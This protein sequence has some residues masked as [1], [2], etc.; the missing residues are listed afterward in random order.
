[1]GIERTQSPE[2]LQAEVDFSKCQMYEIIKA[3][4]EGRTVEFESFSPYLADY[5]TKTGEIWE[6]KLTKTDT[7]G[8]AIAKML[9]NKFPNAQMV[10]LY[11]EYNSEMPYATDIRGRPK[12]GPQI[13]FPEAVKLNFRNNIE[14]LLKNKGVIE[15]EGKEKGNY[16]FVSESSKIKDAEEL[17][18]RLEDVG[19]ITR[20]G[21]AIYFINSEAENPDYRKIPLRTKNGRWLCEALDASSYLDPKNLEITHLVILPNVFKEEQDK[22]WEILRV[23]GIKPTNYH[24]IFFDENLPPDEVVNTIEEE[25]KNIEKKSASIGIQAAA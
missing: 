21:Q 15:G 14:Q 13:E 20:D 11:D 25:I 23:L 16:L 8:I 10:S 24:N 22:V 17:V 6:D 12:P 3:Y 9:K 19:K 2:E 4:Q 5:N 1:M 7:I 18:K